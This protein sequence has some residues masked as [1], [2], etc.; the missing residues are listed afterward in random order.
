M[1]TPISRP[2]AAI[3]DSRWL[4]LVVPCAG[5]LALGDAVLPATRRR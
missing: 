5:M 2:F 1:R 4:A 3:G